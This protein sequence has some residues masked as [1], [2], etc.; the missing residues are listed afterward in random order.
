MAVHSNLPRCGMVIDVLGYKIVFSQTV[1]KKP[2][3]RFT[4][5]AVLIF[6]LSGMDETMLEYV[7]EQYLY[8]IIPPLVV[9]AF[10]IAL[11]RYRIKKI[12]A[13][14]GDGSNGFVFDELKKSELDEFNQQN[15]QIQGTF[16]TKLAV[17][18]KTGVFVGEKEKNS[19]FFSGIPYA[20]PPVGERRWKALEPLPE[21]KDVF[22][23]KHFGASAIQVDYDGSILKHHRQSEDCLTLNICIESKR[24]ERKKPVIVFFHHGDFTYGGSADPLLHGENFTKMRR[25][26]PAFR[27][28]EERRK[29][30]SCFFSC[31]VIM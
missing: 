9:F 7:L 4:A 3:Y 23:A 26:A 29:F 8:V 10:K 18:T 20:K 27:H 12:R 11:R 22:E 14:Y 5:F 2:A 1:Q 15:R 13:R 6:I 21:S 31:Q 16:N 17:K 28:G 24:T 30:L 19:L 25:E